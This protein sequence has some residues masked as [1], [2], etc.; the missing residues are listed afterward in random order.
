MHHEFVLTEGSAKVATDTNCFTSSAN[1]KSTSKEYFSN[2]DSGNPKETEKGVN[3][4]LDNNQGGN[5]DSNSVSDNKS[6]KKS[7]KKQEYKREEN[8]H[9]LHCWAERFADSISA[10][11]SENRIRKR[12]AKT[13]F[14]M[15]F[16]SVRVSD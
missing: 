7:K 13:F 10:L 9:S 16:A 6:N 5:K 12:R 15:V 3:V 1:T 14:T 2:S 11:T 4:K 8:C